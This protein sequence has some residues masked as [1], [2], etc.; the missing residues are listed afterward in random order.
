[1]RPLGMTTRIWSFVVAGVAAAAL[2]G[3]GSSGSS[4]SPSTTSG[5]GSGAGAPGSGR[6]SS[7][8]PTPSSLAPTRGA[9]SPTIRPADFSSHITNP[10]VPLPRGTKIPLVGTAENGK[11][12]Q[13]DV[14]IVTNR[15]QKILGV[16]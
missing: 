12:P 16:A 8:G 10:Y 2:L 3:C 1:M 6:P 14:S 11:T 15:T 7:P 13:T 9:Y 5:A 4:T